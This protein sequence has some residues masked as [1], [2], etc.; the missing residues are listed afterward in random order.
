MVACCNK[1]VTMAT[2]EASQDQALQSTLNSAMR[3][4]VKE[5]LSDDTVVGTFFNVVKEGLRDPAMH[6][7]ALKGAVTAANPLK[8]V[9]VPSLPSVENPLKAVSKTLKDAIVDD[10]AKRLAEAS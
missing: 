8:D 2:V 3:N 7:A 4:G 9:S 1:S 5:A 6:R 10:E